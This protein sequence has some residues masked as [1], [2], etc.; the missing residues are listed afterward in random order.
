MI[1]KWLP[2]AL[3]SCSPISNAELQALE[4]HILNR[5]VGQSE[6]DRVVL[7]YLKLYLQLKP[8]DAE[9][10]G[11][12]REFPKTIQAMIDYMKLFITDY[13]EEAVLPPSLVRIANEIAKEEKIPDTLVFQFLE[14]FVPFFRRETEKRRMYYSNLRIGCNGYL[15]VYINERL[16]KEWAEYGTIP[17]S[18]TVEGHTVAILRLKTKEFAALKDKVRELLQASGYIG[19]YSLANI[20]RASFVMLACNETPF[21]IKGFKV[22]SKEP[23]LPFYETRLWDVTG[24]LQAIEK[25]TGIGTRLM[26]ATEVLGKTLHQDVIEIK[27]VPEARAFYEKLGYKPFG[28]EEEDGSVYMRKSLSASVAPLAGGSRRSSRRRTRRSVARHSRSRSRRTATRTRCRSRRA[29]KRLEK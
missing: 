28:Q 16:E 15:T 2:S 13:V 19:T 11:D 9:C 25:G 1:N 8:S 20:E 10:D 7:S 4:H 26:K 6:Y 17:T 5:D 29:R 3:V 27:S 22:I 12:P 18:I 24:G 14:V 21:Q 23:M